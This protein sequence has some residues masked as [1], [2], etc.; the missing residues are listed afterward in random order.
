M[1][2]NV[3]N[4]FGW[5]SSRAFDLTEENPN[6]VVYF[7]PF[8]RVTIDE[9]LIF[10]FEELYLDAWVRGEIRM[11]PATLFLGYNSAISAA[12]EFFVTEHADGSLRKLYMHSSFERDSE[13]TNVRIGHIY[14][15]LRRVI[16]QGDYFGEIRGNNITT[17][18]SISS[19]S[20]IS[21]CYIHV[22]SLN[23]VK[24]VDFNIYRG[25]DANGEKIF[26]ERYPYFFFARN[27]GEIN[28]IL[29]NG[30]GFCRIEFSVPGNPEIAKLL[31]GQNYIGRE[32]IYET[33][34]PNYNGIHPTISVDNSGSEYFYLDTNIP[35]N[36]NAVGNIRTLETKIEMPGLVLTEIG[37]SYVIE[38]SSDGEISL[39]ADV[40][41]VNPWMGFDSYL[42]HY[43]QC[44][45]TKEWTNGDVKENGEWFIDH[46]TLKIY[47]SNNAGVKSST[48]ETEGDFEWSELSPRNYSF[49]EIKTNE[50]IYVPAQQQMTVFD[51]MVLDGE[52]RVDGNLVI[53]N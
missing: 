7:G 29:D 33:D 20:L 17:N 9:E 42:F 1:T 44:L 50:I 3:T 46:E 47:Q 21:A 49:N 52:I 4:S 39:A 48:F 5:G 10:S 32:L 53:R 22:G 43:D 13:T 14:N 8:N 30:S 19:D 11:S 15:F 2:L 25:T 51:E 12:G 27:V 40:T 18:I 35:F 6:S 38:F 23:A 34:N 36:G 26:S 28:R 37:E 31:K 45:V 41:N 16:Q 24:P